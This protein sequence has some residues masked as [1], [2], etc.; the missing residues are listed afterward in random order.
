MKFY[1]LLF[2]AL[3]IIFTFWN[4]PAQE[5]TLVDEAVAR[6]NTDIITRSALLKAQ[7]AYKAELAQRFPND[8]KSQEKE[9]EQ[10]SGQILD[11]LIEDRLIS[12]RATELGIDVESEVNRTILALAKQTNPQWT[13]KDFEEAFKAQGGDIDDLRKNIR[14]DAQRRVLLFREVINPI[15]EKLSPADKLAWY[16]KNSDKFKLPGTYTLSEIFITTEGRSDAEASA[17]AKQVVSEARGGRAFV[18]LV[19]AYSDPNRPTTA[20][21]GELP[22][23]K[24]AEMAD[25]LRKAVDSLKNGDVSEPIKLDK[26]YQ[27]VQVV[28][29]KAPGLRPF[30]EVE[31]D[32]AQEL[33][34]EKGNSELKNYFKGLKEKSYIRIAEA[35]KQ[36]APNTKP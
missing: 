32:V 5:P 23:F 12:Q 2:V 28:D 1:R 34:F 30:S 24:E 20:K 18:D 22:T 16:E 36:G 19:K 13:L 14:S 9:F 27:I 17:L 4:V 31:A 8:T 11:L 33:A 10:N 21:K 6:V 26:G 29:H 25:Y 3:F 35:Y 15:Y 7:Q